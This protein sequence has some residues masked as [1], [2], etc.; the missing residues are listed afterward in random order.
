MHDGSRRVANK[1][2]ETS[3]KDN[4]QTPTYRGLTNADEQSRSVRNRH[5]FDDALH[6]GCIGQRFTIIATNVILHIFA[7]RFFVLFFPKKDSN[8][9]P[10]LCLSVCL[11][12]CLSACLSL[13][14][15]WC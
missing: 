15:S 5:Q 13:L 10:A 7:E 14:L 8:P 1:T 4:A 9:N 12:V 6:I 3:A 2:N 11:S